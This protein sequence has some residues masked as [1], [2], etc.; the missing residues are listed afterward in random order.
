MTVRGATPG[1]SEHFDAVIVGSGFGGSVTAA[2]L[3]EAGW[4]VC[5]LERGKAYPPNS[6]PRSPLGMKHNLWDP[7]EGRHGLFDL[8]EFDHLDALC[9]SGLGGGSLIYA[10]VFLRKDERWFVNENLLEGGYED[11][12]VTRADLD[13]HYDEVERRIGVQRFPLEQSPYDQTPKV[14]AYREAA[15][16][17]GLDWSLVPLAVT[18]ANPDAP[19]IP[20]EPI[21]EQPN[22]HG[23]TRLTCRLCGEC[24]IGCNYG[25]KNTLDFTYLT[26]A[27]RAGA[28]L[29][30]R[31][32]V[33]SFAPLDGGGYE[34]KYVIHGPEREGQATATATL[35]PER[36]TCTH[37]ILSAGTLGTNWLLLRN[38]AALPG[39][40]PALGRGFSGNGDLL[41][42]ALRATQAD[43]EG[44]RSPRVIEPGRG[45]V[46]TS[47]IRVADSLDGG[48]GRGFYLEDAGYPEFA[49]WMLELLEAPEAIAR[50][51]PRAA[52]FVWSMM[53]GRQDTELGEMASALFGDCDLSS[54][55]LPLLGMGRDVPDGTMSLKDGRLE[56]AWS[57]DGPSKPYFDR[58]RELSRQVAGQLGA[59]FL[60][61][62][63]WHQ[64]RVITVHALGGSR[65]GRSAQEGVVD[66]YGRVHGHPGLHIADG[67]VMPGPVGANP[68]LTI[69]ALADRFAT[70]MLQEPAGVSVSIPD[71]PASGP[72]PAPPADVDDPGLAGARGATAL[73]FTEEMKG[74][75]TFGQT[76][77]QA[78]FETGQ[79]AQT[80]F[81]FHLTIETDDIDR[82]VADAQHAAR[83]RGWIESDVFGGRL[84]VTRGD[85]NLFVDQSEPGTRRMLYRL[86]FAD[87]QQHP[88]TMT[89][90]KEVRH[91]SLLHV[92]PETTTL[93]THVLAG[94]VP[95]SAEDA[96]EVV[97]GGIIHI[98]PLDFARQM[99]T[100]RVHPPDRVDAVGKFGRLF[101]G[102]LWD[103]YGPHAKASA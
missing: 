91:G 72:D 47:A 14:L 45:P 10:N 94:H 5:L 80:A 70:A 37:L 2:R 103:V 43:A 18:F 23:R 38:R 25:S 39:L 90:F 34:V 16:K 63:I 3:A 51:L 71:P 65:M 61:N 77:F 55:L 74:F 79:E 36:L 58:V 33:R 28:D 75:V 98:H 53:R 22:L 86:E 7:S 60:D 49:G 97:A 84:E 87:G 100:F 1:A 42:F 68:S 13:P 96:A 15:E 54:G 29:R 85:F 46:I 89:G 66:P 99:T 20:G 73:E 52:D 27:W 64:H 78:G 82:F 101:A 4:R 83:A 88:L 26:D 67:S 95:F 57:K 92:W 24:D 17:L 31:C 93:Y 48:Q 81:M 50:A 8:W 35:A 9:A 76:D 41:T 19:A 69:A 44:R 32:E 102:E 56:V 12:P 30:T 11:W 40:S 62:P 6:F 21:T 59:D